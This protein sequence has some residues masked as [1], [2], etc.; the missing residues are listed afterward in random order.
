MRVAAATAIARGAKD[1]GESA[2]IARGISRGVERLTTGAIN[3]YERDL[4]V[5]AARR[6]ARRNGRL[7]SGGS[8]S[9][10]EMDGLILAQDDEDELAEDAQSEVGDAGTSWE[11][12]AADFRRR[13]QQA[14]RDAS[15]PWRWR[16]T[17]E[18]QE[19]TL[20]QL[21]T[22]DRVWDHSHSEM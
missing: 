7:T 16:W 13:A 4:I 19:V 3:P 6:Q 8:E 10:E 2:R 15:G 14:L 18:E 20:D 17:Q 22:D 11:S 1:D 9:D 21:G 12:R 5:S